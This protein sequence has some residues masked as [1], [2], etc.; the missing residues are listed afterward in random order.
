MIIYK[1]L[2]KYGYYSFRLEILEYCLKENVRNREQ[3]YLDLMK[4]EYNVLVK[5]GSSLAFIH[6]EESLL[7]LRTHLKE[8]NNKKGNIVVVIDTYTNLSLTYDSLRKAAL[9]LNANLKSL[10]YSNKVKTL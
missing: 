8:L 4:S 9:A 3:Y 2:L 7:K 1:S 6:L 5:A 10:I